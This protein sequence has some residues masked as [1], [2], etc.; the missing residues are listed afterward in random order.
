MQSRP[1]IQFL[2]GLA[3]LLVVFFHLQ[4]DGFHSGFLGVD[5]FFVISGYL[6]ASIYQSECHQGFLLRRAKRLLPA[7]FYSCSR[8]VSC[9]LRSRDTRRLPADRAAGVIGYGLCL[10]YRL[11]GRKFLLRQGSVQAPPP[12]VVTR[13]GN[14]ILS[15]FANP[16]STF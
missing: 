13:R 14:S 2:R 12:L 4:I 15:I 1:D 6:M 3:V 10:E 16:L 7:L 5:I 9:R 11:L 8:Y